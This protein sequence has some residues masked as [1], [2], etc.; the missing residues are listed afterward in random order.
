M[1]PCRCPLCRALLPGPGSAPRPQLLSLASFASTAAEESVR[2][3]EDLEPR[4]DLYLREIHP[5][6]QDMLEALQSS[7]LDSPTKTRILSS[8][9]RIHLRFFTLSVIRRLWNPHLR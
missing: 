5:D 2:V 4:L 8:M 7:S 3:L 1:H 6:R 9:L